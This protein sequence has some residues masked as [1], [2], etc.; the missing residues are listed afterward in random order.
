[1]LVW[2]IQNV[3]AAMLLVQL[4]S[5]T[6]PVSESTI[7]SSLYNFNPGCYETLKLLPQPVDSGTV[8]SYSQFHVK[9]W[10]KTIC[11]DILL[12]KLILSVPG[13]C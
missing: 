10:D 2:N 11:G 1:M 6:L 12:A 13:D 7:Q 8:L 5:R 4:M 3:L 9:M